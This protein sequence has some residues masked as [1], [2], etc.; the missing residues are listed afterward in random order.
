MMMMM[1]ETG[2]V[3]HPSF[4]NNENMY[5]GPKA[6]NNKTTLNIFPDG[7]YFIQQS[8]AYNA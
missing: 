3:I 6:L 8:S 2:S 1:T 7:F 4:S 5:Y